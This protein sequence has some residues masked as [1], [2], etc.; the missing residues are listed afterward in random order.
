[1]SNTQEPS[2]NGPGPE[3]V[4]SDPSA[5]PAVQPE[6]SG[7]AQYAPPEPPFV[8]PEPQQPPASYA[9]PQYAPPQNAEQPQYAPPQYA[10]QPQ[11]AP[12]QQVPGQQDPG[13][14]QYTGQPG[15]PGQQPY[16]GQPGQP[17]QPGAPGQ[18]PYGPPQGP[19]EPKQ[20]NLVG[21]IGFIVAI[22]GFIV[23]CIPPVVW[24]SWILLPA[25]LVLGIVALCLKGKKK[26]LGIAALGISVVGAIVSAVVFFVSLAMMFGQVVSDSSNL[27]DLSELEEEWGDAQ[28]PEATEGTPVDPADALPLGT[29]IE[30]GDWTYTINS[31]DFDAVDEIAAESSVNGSP[32]AGMTYILVNVTSEY[33]GSGSGE[34]QAAPSLFLSFVD[35]DGMTYTELQKTLIAPDDLLFQSPT[36]SEGKTTGNLAL[37]VPE[38]TAE[39]GVLAVDTTLADPAGD[40][41]FIAVK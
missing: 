2:E 24:V 8:S 3:G 40:E 33:S 22:V 32:E 16:P 29:P 14:Q 41:T 6:A 1:M 4:E 13:Q 10:Q 30:A 31:V 7:G 38:A 28:L 25:A 17:G 26:G 36:E 19:R 5:E 34:G 23:A 12:P 39:E 27:P 37:Q 21:L 35:P 15:Y 20:P 9:P 18:G 11:Y